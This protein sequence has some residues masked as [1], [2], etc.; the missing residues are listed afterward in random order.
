MV[1]WANSGEQEAIATALASNA[2]AADI[3]NRAAKR[4]QELTFN[5]VD[6]PFGIFMSSLPP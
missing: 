2:S 3:L 1:V 5:M 4:R 6:L